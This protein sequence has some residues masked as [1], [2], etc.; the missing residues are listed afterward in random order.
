[1]IDGCHKDEFSHNLF[2]VYNEGADMGIAVATRQPPP[3]RVGHAQ[4]RVQHTRTGVVH[5]RTGVVHT[6][7]S[8]GYTKASVAHTQVQNLFRVYNE[9]AMS[10]QGKLSASDPAS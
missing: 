2:R 6:R 10:P 7:T 3:P 1:M 8:A 5:T 4:G 9:G